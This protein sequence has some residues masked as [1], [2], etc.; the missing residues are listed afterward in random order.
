HPQAL[1]G[2]AAL[3]KR[4]NPGAAPA[5]PPKATEPEREPEPP[6]AIVPAAQAPAET[7]A[8][9]ALNVDYE[10]LPAE[11]DPFQCPFCGRQTHP[12]DERCR[13]C[14]RSLL[15]PGFWRGG[16]YL[17]MILIVTGLL[18]Q[19]SLL[20]ALG[21]FLLTSYPQQAARL[22]FANLWTSP[23][24]L[25]ALLRVV[26]WAIVVL[27]LLGDYDGGFG[28][29]AVVALVD[30]VWRCGANGSLAGL[31][32]HRQ[33]CAGV[34]GFPDWPAGG[35]QPGAGPAAAGGSARPRSD[36]GRDF[37]S[38]RSVVRA[39]GQVGAGGAALAARHH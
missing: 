26:A 5:E 3:R 20:Q 14:G 34:G 6:A 8:P 12:D 15:G 11:D 28:V 24:L 31:A 17:Y 38:A 2:A 23:L 25:P 21:A 10:T 18:L 29:T 27:L 9:A 39:A 30:L 35:D 13:H 37:S 22:P 16:G 7:S 19:S 33:Y 36:R 1:A 4:L 32:G